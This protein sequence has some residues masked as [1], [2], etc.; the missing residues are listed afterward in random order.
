MSPREPTFLQPRSALATF[1]EVIASGQSLVMHIT[2]PPRPPPLGGRA[3]DAGHAARGT[4]RRGERGAARGGARDASARTVGHCKRTILLSRI[5]IR[6]TR[7]QGRAHLAPRGCYEGSILIFRCAP[8]RG[9]KV[10]RCFGNPHVPM[11]RIGCASVLMTCVVRSS[12]SSSE[13]S[14]RKYFRDSA[15]Q[16]VCMVSS[17]PLFSWLTFLIPE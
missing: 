1:F 11:I 3:A 12:A 8:F 13:K 2:P 10:E 6:Y 4:R 15:I 16:K 14:R 9:G 5:S 7:R 17:L